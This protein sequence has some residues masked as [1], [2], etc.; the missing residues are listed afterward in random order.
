MKTKARDKLVDMAARVRC[1]KE[2]LYGLRKPLGLEE[3][4]MVDM[5]ICVFEDV[6]DTIEDALRIE[7]GEE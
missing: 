1:A 7:D 5:I 6:A 4:K 3:S 2:S